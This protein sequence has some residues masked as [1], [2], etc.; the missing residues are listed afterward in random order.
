MKQICLFFLWL[1]LIQAQAQT[2][3]FAHITDT[4]I[5]GSTGTE[6]L[7]RTVDD[8]NQQPDIDLVILSGDITEFGSVD[9]L[10]EAKALLMKLKKPYYI[11]PGNHDSKWSESGNNSF[12]RIFGAEGFSFEK[13][14][15]LF[16]GTASG[17]N[18]RMAPGLVPR[19][20]MVFLD[21]IL[22]HMKNPDQPIILVN[23][24]PL[25]ESLSN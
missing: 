11:L 15:F 24:Y 22:G 14:G 3:R 23:H 13:N 25:D 5:G 4:H 19:E 1:F 9:E 6:D 12:V 16:I 10:L 7:I 17:P 18:M 21:F 8:I 20:Q 2:F